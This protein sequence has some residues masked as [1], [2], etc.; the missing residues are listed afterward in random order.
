[1]T[2]EEITEELFEGMTEKQFQYNVNKNSIEYD[3]KHFA[4]CNGGQSKIAKKLNELNDEINLMKVEL[5]THK[6]PLWSTREAE[7]IL[8]L[9]EKKIIELTDLLVEEVKKNG[10]LLLEINSLRKELM[11]C[12]KQKRRF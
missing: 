5:N 1:M 7:R 6:H 3:G 12:K 9:K 8:N 10:G 11:I 4:Y 2:W